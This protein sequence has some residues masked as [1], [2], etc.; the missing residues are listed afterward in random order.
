MVT[1]AFEGKISRPEGPFDYHLLNSTHASV[2]MPDRPEAT[3]VTT[4]EQVLKLVLS[5]EG[6]VSVPLVWYPRLAHATQDERD[7]WELVGQGQGIRWSD[8]DEDLS[9][10]GVIAGRAV[11]RE[12]AVVR[13]VA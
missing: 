13:T 8:L 9:V 10:E 11:R 4:T 7:K 5:D 1:F 3:D 2:V 12:P 6:T